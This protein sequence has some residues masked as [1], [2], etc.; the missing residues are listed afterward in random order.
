MASVVHVEHVFKKYSRNANIHLSY[1]LGDLFNHLLGRKPSLQ[2]RKD[3]FWA[4]HDI[5]FSLEQGDTLALIGRNGSGKSTL[6]KM[7]N[8]LIKMD[9]GR[10]I[11]D[12]RVQALINLGAGFNGALS[13]LDNIYNSAALNGFN[14]KQTKEIA[15]QVIEFAELEEFINSPVETYSSGM[16]ARLGFAVAVH[17]KPEILL[18]DE[19]LAVGDYAFQNRCFTRMQQLKKSGVTIVLVSHAHTSV[20]Q[21]CDR[22]I[23]LHQGK[24]MMMGEAPDT[25]KAYLAFLDGLESEKVN[26]ENRKRADIKQKAVKSNE[27]SE[28]KQKQIRKENESLYGPIHTDLGVVTNLQVTVESLGRN[29]GSIVI[30][31]PLTISYQ[32]D[33]SRTVED[34]NI[35]VK[36]LR[37]DG[38]NL[39]T[40]STLNGDLVRDIHS[41]RVN[42]K[43]V[44]PDFD[45]N[46]GAYVLVLAIH[47]GKSYLHRDIVREFIVTSRNTFTWGIRDFHYQYFRD[48]Q[49]IYDSQQ[50]LQSDRREHN[51]IDADKVKYEHL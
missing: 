38:L 6:L 37:K 33:L 22:A 51:S 12:G 43:I 27:Q 50:N 47:E 26:E 21:L 8:G 41:G 18:I 19:I 1:G 35:T 9:A 2:L 7:M 25:V 20:I 46:P 42:C 30:H 48:G 14:R 5:S 16:K 32:F 11:M 15:D 29:V 23:W 36:F 31:D 40:I 10:I 3:E 34:L 39:T 28:P 44:I 49:L 4:V 17:L 13:G 45:F 24:M